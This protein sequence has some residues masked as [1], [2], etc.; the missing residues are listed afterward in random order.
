MLAGQSSRRSIRTGR[1]QPRGC[2]A[3]ACVKDGHYPVLNVGV[4]L[5]TVPLAAFSAI[6]QRTS[7][8]ALYRTSYAARFSGSRSTS[9]ASMTR[10]KRRGR[11]SPYYRDGSGSPDDE[12]PARSWPRR[13]WGLIPEFHNSRRNRDLHHILYREDHPRS[14]PPKGREK[15]GRSR[16][17]NR[18]APL[19]SGR[20]SPPFSRPY[21]RR[22]HSWRSLLRIAARVGIVPAPCFL[23]GSVI[24]LAG[25]ESTAI[26]P[27][28]P[29]AIANA[30]ATH[31][32]N[33]L[34]VGISSL[35]AIVEQA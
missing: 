26:K 7:E 19:L 27:T 11:R 25:G 30:I 22:A 9:C 16:P 23:C 4:A 17:L 3:G 21:A 31:F 14:P 10:S 20:L 34:S 24:G 32:D 1:S 33:D 28:K 8:W 18:V 35:L 12:T 15:G 2:C 5:D 6:F 29:M 13:P